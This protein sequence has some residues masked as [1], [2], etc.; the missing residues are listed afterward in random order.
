[1]LNKRSHLTTI[2]F[3][4]RITHYVSE[5]G[6]DYFDMWFRKLSPQARSRVQTRLD[7]IEFGNFGDYKSL[8]KGVYEIRIHLGPGYRVYFGRDG[9]DLVI[10]LGGGTKKRQTRD[11]IQTQ[12]HWEAYKQEKANADKTT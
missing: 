6:T 4:V 3:M 7:R 1:M 8:G 11:I 9:D 5:N 2:V 10:L 12:A